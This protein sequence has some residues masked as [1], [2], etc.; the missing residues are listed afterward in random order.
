MYI[1][2]TVKK[3]P[4]STLNSY[5]PLQDSSS[6]E[7]TETNSKYSVQ[8]VNPAKRRDLT[9]KK[10]KKSKSDDEH[11][12]NVKALLQLAGDSDSSI[13]SSPKR[14]KKKARRKR[15]TISSDDSDDDQ[16]LCYVCKQTIMKDIYQNHVEKCIE[17]RE[18]GVMV[19]SDDNGR[20]CRYI[21]R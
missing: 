4:F 15:K 3:N 2:C 20:L 8:Q 6:D 17:E 7:S 11:D 12:A 13:N 21:N 16:L 14:P 19:S 9:Y 10:K 18:E 1:C 5:I